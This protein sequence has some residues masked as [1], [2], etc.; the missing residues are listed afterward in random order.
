[1]EEITCKQVA[2]LTGGKW[3]KMH[4][5]AKRVYGIDGLAPTIHTMGGG[6]L[7]P[8][9]MEEP[10]ALDEQNKCVRTDG[11]IGT[12]TTDGSSPKHNNRVIEPIIYDDYNGRIKAD[13]SANGTLTT[14]CGSDAE[15][16]GVKII[17]PSER[18]FKQAFETATENECTNGD[19]IDAYNG[20]VNK[21]GVSPTVTTRPEG[22][23]TAIL[24]IQNYRIRKL[25]PKECYR[26]MGFDDEDFYKAAYGREIPI[27]LVKRLEKRDL[28]RNEWK[29]LWRHL[30]KQEVSN[31][32]LY[33]QAGNSIV[34]K[35]LEAIFREMF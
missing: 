7:E 10:I 12:L 35:V 15:R 27:P 31:S 25:T 11:T 34:V 13:Q 1:M 32:Q 20:K 16:N 30:R 19:I 24:P 28:K 8:K 2:T 22:F 4:D 29:E 18:F 3:D 21:D 23:K 26:L 17:E 14:N 33:K 5:I 6:N 9:I